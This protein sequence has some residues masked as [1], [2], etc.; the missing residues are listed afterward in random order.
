MLAVLY[1][2]I[3]RR[4]KLDLCVKEDNG[5]NGVPAHVEECGERV[6]AEC[7]PR[8]GATAEHR[9]QLE[10][11]LRHRPRRVEQRRRR[12]CGVRGGGGGVRVRC[13]GKVS[14]KT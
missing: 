8:V 5:V 11:E 14:K 2:Y 6:C 1:L 4:L 13:V 10:L 7:R 9:V 12:G 3:V